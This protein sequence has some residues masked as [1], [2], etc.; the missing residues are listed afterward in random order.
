MSSVKDSRL[1]INIDIAQ[2]KRKAKELTGDLT[3]MGNAGLGGGQRI[4][5]GMQQASMGITQAAD[6]AA[7][8]QI[9]F[10]TMTQGMLNLSTSAIQ[11]FTSISN[12]ARAENRAK[13]STI[14]VAR[15]EDL[16]A[17]KRERLNDL[18]KS[19]IASE[20]KM[21][22][23]RKEIATATAD[24][25]VKQEKMEIEIG[26]VLDIQLLFF[27][28]LTNVGVS[29]YQTLSTML[30]IHTKAL[31]K[32]TIMTK[33]NS[34]AQINSKNVLFGNTIQRKI[35]SFAIMTSTGVT[36]AS[37]VAVRLQTAA[38]HGLKIALG[39]VGLI[40]IG[41]SAAMLAYETNVLG[42]KDAVNSLLGIQDD[43]NTELE[44]TLSGMNEVNAATLQFGDTLQFT[45][46]SSLGAAMR[47]LAEYRAQI[48]GLTAD[49]KAMQQ[50][51]KDIGLSPEAAKLAR[52]FPL[53][54][55]T[56]LPKFLEGGIRVILG[57]QR[58]KAEQIRLSTLD[59]QGHDPS[60]KTGFTGATAIVPEVS[61]QVVANLANL[62]VEQLASLD[63]DQQKAIIFQTVVEPTIVS[64]VA[65]PVQRRKLLEDFKLFKGLEFITPEQAR[66]QGLETIGDA[67]GKFEK[68]LAVLARKIRLQSPIFRRQEISRLNK[69]A[70]SQFFPTTLSKQIPQ[71]LRN[72]FSKAKG[73]RGNIIDGTFFGSKKDELA[74]LLA[75]ERRKVFGD[76]DFGTSTG[77][78]LSTRIGLGAIFNS[79]F[80]GGL[81]VKGGIGFLQDIGRLQKVRGTI[82]PIGLDIAGGSDR[83]RVLRELGIGGFDGAVAF[84]IS[85]FRDRDRRQ[86]FLKAFNETGNITQALQDSHKFTK[87][88]LKSLKDRQVIRAIEDN[89]RNLLR[90]GG[91]H[92]L[93]ETGEPL[94]LSDPNAIIGGFPNLRA[95]RRQARLDSFS[96]GVFI[97]SFE[98]SA[99]FGGRRRNLV[100]IAFGIRRTLIRT[101][102]IGSIQGVGRFGSQSSRI[103]NATIL[104]EANRRLTL[105]NT[106]FGIDPGFLEGMLTSTSADLSARINAQN[107]Y[108]N[109]LTRMLELDRQN[110]IKIRFD[111]DRGDR[112]L[113][114]RLLYKERLD[115]ASSGT[116]PI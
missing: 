7:A 87:N 36:R 16:L 2:A 94:P 23:I 47:Q 48:Q 100:N 116:S 68:D 74:L 93:D 71:D 102:L 70:R 90:N 92:R 31:I 24:L 39:P 62:T 89:N 1:R 57:N 65:D 86:A 26:A 14:A 21:I 34:L 66:F 61:I 25:T 80:A 9:R 108:I 96:A 17:N 110:V 33:V 77:S 18:V 78:A 59:E 67:R 5:Q 114:N 113:D 28:S 19:G 20:Q 55:S 99:G 46:P 97:G 38:L 84:A 10:Q 63:P 35:N 30:S 112:E 105:G 56:S 69:I 8:A 107:E 32:N 50:V 11:T 44:D 88:Q 29:A 12:L 15:A 60:I 73:E 13:A 45:L 40:L 22:N 91:R 104:A 98:T 111:L 4:N 49:T 42:V 83:D 54:G 106:L 72:A 37:T 109:N 75:I 53:G 27:A 58:A 41:I 82:R 115:A 6:S 3:K 64:F 101:G 95:F 79:R 43:M 76:F 52:S 51:A 85:N 81:G 103:H